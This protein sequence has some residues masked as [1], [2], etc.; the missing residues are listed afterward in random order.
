MVTGLFNK[1]N[2]MDVLCC[3]KRSL[4]GAGTIIVGG[5]KPNCVKVNILL[6]PHLFYMKDYQQ[7]L[8]A[9]TFAICDLT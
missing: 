8:V 7:L 4:S 5:T 6:Q 3:T 1:F 2:E 9:N